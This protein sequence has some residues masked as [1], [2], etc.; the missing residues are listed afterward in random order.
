LELL[1]VRGAIQ[2]FA[3]AG[4]AFKNRKTERASG[5]DRPSA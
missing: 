4:F 5:F 3:S 1:A 2:P